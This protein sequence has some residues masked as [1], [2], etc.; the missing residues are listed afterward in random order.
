MI[1]LIQ[2]FNFF[3]KHLAFCYKIKF[4][5]KASLKC[6]VLFTL[7]VSSHLVNNNVPIF[8]YHYFRLC[9]LN[10]MYTVLYGALSIDCLL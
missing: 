5:S 2:V 10:E 3:P 4:T 7:R 8:A 9:E 6:N 1:F